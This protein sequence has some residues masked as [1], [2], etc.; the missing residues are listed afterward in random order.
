MVLDVERPAVEGAPVVPR[1]LEDAVGLERD[2]HVLL[3]GRERQARR[4]RF[5]V[6]SVHDGEE[7]APTVA[8]VYAAL[9]LSWAAVLAEVEDV[10]PDD[11][12]DLIWL[13]VEGAALRRRALVC[14]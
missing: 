3:V 2:V 13:L 14:N 12:G 7:S 5:V 11:A 6:A 8:R 10:V 4:L 9:E 1:D